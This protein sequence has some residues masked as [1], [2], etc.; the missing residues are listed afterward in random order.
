MNEDL[1][2]LRLAVQNALLGYTTHE[3]RAVYVKI[4]NKI[5]YLTMIFDGEISEYWSEIAPEIGTEIISH[6]SNHSIHENFMRKDY[7][8]KLNFP[9]FICVYKRYEK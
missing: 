9:D 3:L 8:E 6:F 2:T 5:I 1:L 7:P 4:S